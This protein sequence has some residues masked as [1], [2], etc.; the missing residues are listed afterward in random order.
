MKGRAGS[1]LVATSSHLLRRLL[2]LALAA[3]LAPVA[4]PSR[5]QQPPAPPAPAEFAA[6]LAELGLH[7]QAVDELQRLDLQG[8]P[9]WH[10]RTLGYGYGAR[11]LRAGLAAE[12]AEVLTASGETDADPQRAERQKPLLALALARSGQVARAV[13]ILSRLETFGATAEQRGQALAIRCMVHLSAAEADQGGPCARQLLGPAADPAALADLHTDVESQAF[14]HGAAS[15]LLPGLGQSLGGQWADAGAAVLVNGGLGYSTWSLAADG[16]Y[17]DSALLGLGLT[18][19]Y[20]IG[21]IEHG[22]AAGRQAA[23][24]RRLRGARR[25]ADLL[26]AVRSGP[27]EAESSRPQ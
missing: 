26:A 6:Y 19:R 11:L 20:Y 25:L 17:V 4:A 22:A 10:A 5:A 12:A 8:Q 14:W 18:I 7:R 15:A 16:L 23:L 2:P 21:N 1:R 9:Q 24:K 27:V 13:A 3:L